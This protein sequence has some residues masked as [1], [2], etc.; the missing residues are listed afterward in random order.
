[1]SGYNRK[2]DAYIAKTEP[3]AQE[4][5]EH[6]RELVHQ[7]CPEVEET[8]KWSF[9]HFEY[10]GILCSMAGFKRHCVFGFWKAAI[11]QDRY[12]VM[13]IG[14]EKNAM[15]TFDR[16]TNLDDLPADK[17]LLQYVK[18]AVKLNEDD[19]R[20]PTKTQPKAKPV[21]MPEDFLKAL[22]KNKVALKNF[23]AFSNSQRKEYILW[24]EEA[25]REETRLR[26]I[27][28]AVEWLS[29]RKPRD[30]KYIKK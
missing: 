20:L 11:M 28:T 19:I 21:R 13:S 17:I 18:E 27:K 30:W 3:F 8:I 6:L 10:K 22:K 24:I 14:P 23:E 5:L 4:I 12:Q 26:R 7:A 16:I 1:M 25:K 15:G 29:E 9:P 2:V